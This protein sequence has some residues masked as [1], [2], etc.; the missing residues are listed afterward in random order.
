MNMLFLL[1]QKVFSSDHGVAGDVVR[2]RGGLRVEIF[3]GVEP[4]A[5]QREP[6]LR[7]VNYKSGSAG[8][9]VGG[10]LDLTTKNLGAGSTG[11][12]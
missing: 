2:L 5:V 7:W 6:T 9:G 3:D 1:M 11:Q 4:E 12:H 10:P 8:T